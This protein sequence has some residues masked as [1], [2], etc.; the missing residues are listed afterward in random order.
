MAAGRASVRDTLAR[1]I[2]AMDPKV[3]LPHMTLAYLEALLLAA[4]HVAI[5]ALQDML[6]ETRARSTPFAG[7]IHA[8]GRKVLS[9]THWVRLVGASLGMVWGAVGD[10]DK[11]SP[12]RPL[13][14]SA[15]SQMIS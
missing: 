15:I 10:A 3:S 2:H 13:P 14:Q 8:C 7:L 12:D 6:T 1:S 9:Y 5:V 11:N 4:D